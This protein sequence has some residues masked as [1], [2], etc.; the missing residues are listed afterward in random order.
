MQVL[1]DMGAAGVPQ[2]IA[3]LKY[4]EPK[5]RMVAAKRNSF[6]L[7]A[8]RSIADSYGL[9]TRRSLASLT[10]LDSSTAPTL[11]VRGA[12][13]LRWASARLPAPT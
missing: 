5:V 1:V 3:L 10:A 9:A 7:P 8:R 6:S 2:L 11:P 12:A 4:P 13:A